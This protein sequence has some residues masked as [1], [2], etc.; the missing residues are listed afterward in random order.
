MAST[1]LTGE[2]FP[3]W[4]AYVQR[5][6]E[7]VDSGRRIPLGPS[8]PV[9]SSIPDTS[10]NAPKILY[11]APHPDDE[12]LSGAL[13]FR[14]RFEGGARVTNV[15]MTL[16]SDVSQRDR[17]RREIESA[18]RA[19]GFEFVI[20]SSGDFP[21]PAG[22]DRVNL[23]AR[24]ADPEA[25]RRNVEALAAIFDRYQP[26]AVFVPHAEDFNRA[27]IGTHHLVMDALHV[28]LSRRPEANLVVIETEY[29]HQLAEPNLMVGVTPE[30]T[31][32]QITAAAEHGGEMARAPYH[33]LHPCRL[34]DNARRG[35][36]VVG[37]QGKPAQSFSFAELY[38]VSF[39]RDSE[40][41][42]ARLGVRILPPS[43]PATLDWIRREFRPAR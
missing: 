29:W 5:L 41:V 11:C 15:A 14:L 2:R 22:F 27:H 18:C 19:L 10:P 3:E 12:S 8:L 25:W 21:A 34:L 30:I 31:A 7:V 4:L 17:R 9:T 16:G 6:L 43:E 38:R 32:L 39:R 33:L 23:D 37:G 26:E 40:T 20:P 35:S 36:E 28:H 24:D 1:A 13:A 42:P